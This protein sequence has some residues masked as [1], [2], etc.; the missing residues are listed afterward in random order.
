[1]RTK[2]DELILKTA[3]ELSVG[4]ISNSKW[5]KKAHKAAKKANATE[6]DIYDALARLSFDVAESII[7]EGKKRAK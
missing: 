3:T 4:F 2:E 6:R 1:M 5:M 7:N